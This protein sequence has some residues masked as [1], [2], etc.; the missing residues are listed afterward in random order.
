MKSTD[1]IE[2]VANGLVAHGGLLNG[3]WKRRDR[4][5]FAFTRP[6]DQR[7]Q[8][9]ARSLGAEWA[10]D[11]MAP[12]P[13]PLDAAI[14]F[15]ELAQGCTST[16]AYISIHNMV[17]WMIDKFGDD[18]QRHRH[19][20]SCELPTSRARRGYGRPASWRSAAARW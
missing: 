16:A 11:A 18:D 7:A 13:E 3:K 14:I 1:E 2:N 5:V 4:R 9:L 20:Q 17:T 8:S 10:G 19:S 12:G 15:E 6:E